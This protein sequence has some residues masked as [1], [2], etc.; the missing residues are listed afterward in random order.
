MSARLSFKMSF[1][2]STPVDSDGQYMMNAMA[3]HS[4]N[5]AQPANG[6][7]RSHGTMADDDGASLYDD[8]AQDV[9]LVLEAIDGDESFAVLA[10][11]LRLGKKYDFAQLRDGAVTRLEHAFPVTFAAFSQ[12]KSLPA[13]ILLY[14][15][16]AF[17]DVTPA[18]E[19]GL[20]SIFPVAFY[21]ACTHWLDLGATQESIVN[22]VPNSNGSLV[23]LSQTD[24]D[25]STSMKLL[26]QQWEGL[27]SW[28]RPGPFSRIKAKYLLAQPYNG[29]FHGQ[30]HR[31]NLLTSRSSCT[32]RI[33]YM[34]QPQYP[35]FEY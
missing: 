27:Y 24:K 35:S 6:A 34:Y 18:R 12:G 5:P 10:A 30:K 19:I 9:E 7:K 8:M 29:G 32:G 13:T 22:G 15:G 23:H 17:N 4:P 28:V 2:A 26:K 11:M 33:S 16:L 21:G 20:S 3:Q 14:L 25:M 31:H 1:R